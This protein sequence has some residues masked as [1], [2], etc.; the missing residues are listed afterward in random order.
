MI[1][2][3]LAFPP[4]LGVII[5]RKGTVADVSWPGKGKGV[6]KCGESEN[7]ECEGFHTSRVVGGG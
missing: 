7:E 2:V 5:S 6:R 4:G 1:W 3:G